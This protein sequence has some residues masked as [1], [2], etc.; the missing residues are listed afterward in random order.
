MVAQIIFPLLLAC[1]TFFSSLAFAQNSEKISISPNEPWDDISNLPQEEES[2]WG[3]NLLMY[4]PNRVLD[5]IDIFKADVGVG[6]STGAVLRVS[7]YAQVGV[8]SMDPASLRFGLLGRRA[9]ILLEKSSEMGVSPAYTKSKERKICTV[10][11]GA[12]LDLLLVGGYLAFCPDEFIDFLG[13][14]F[15]LDLKDDD[16]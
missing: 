11:I 16:F 9:P 3:Y 14:I 15:L 2:N 7:K 4:I 6:F 13:G 12:G 8:R 5:I 1:A 10:E